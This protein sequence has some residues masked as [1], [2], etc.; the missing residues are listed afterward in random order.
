MLR[1]Y[2]VKILNGYKIIVK[3]GKNQRP[4]SVNPDRGTNRV[5][6]T[7]SM[8]TDTIQVQ[9]PTDPTPT[10]KTNAAREF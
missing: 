5:F 9:L 6:V 1:G 3:K 10:R 7:P 8:R 2:D 4:K